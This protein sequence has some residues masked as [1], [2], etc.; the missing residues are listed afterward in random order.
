MEDEIYLLRVKHEELEN[1]LSIEKDKINPDFNIITQIKKRKLL[2]KDEM[3][4][5]KA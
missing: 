4:R 2:L 3:A 5:L 1:A